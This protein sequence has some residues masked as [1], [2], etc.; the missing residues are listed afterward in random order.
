[1]EEVD[2]AIEIYKPDSWKAYTIGD[3]GRALEISRGASMT[4][5]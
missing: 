1:M 4:S 5:R 2:K 3:P